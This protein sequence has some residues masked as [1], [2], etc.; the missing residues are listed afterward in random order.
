MVRSNPNEEMLNKVVEHIT[1]EDPMALIIM[2]AAGVAG[3]CGQ[4]G[5][6]TRII[7]GL[8]SNENGSG[9]QAFLPGGM[10]N[11]VGLGPGLIGFLLPFLNGQT[12]SASDDP[13]MIKRT[14]YAAS[15]IVEAGL[16]YT[17][18]KNDEVLKAAIDAMK[19][20]VS[21]VSAL[22]VVPV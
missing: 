7:N 22:K 10:W 14:G 8:S 19:N 18:V 12:G 16:M 1:K 4:T 17:L 5:P 20:T 3:M 2:S 6:L 13:D 11:P 21:N 9:V 15:N